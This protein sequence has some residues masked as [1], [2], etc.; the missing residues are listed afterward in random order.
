MT[1]CSR[2]SALLCCVIIVAAWTR[3]WPLRRRALITR[4]TDL[5][6]FCSQ[7]RRCPLGHGCCVATP[8]VCIFLRFSRHHW[9][10][11]GGA[12]RKW[13][14]DCS[15][16]GRSSRAHSNA[17]T[18]AP[19]SEKTLDGNCHASCL[20]RLLDSNRWAVAYVTL[21]GLSAHSATFDCVDHVILHSIYDF[22][23]DG[24]RPPVDR[25]VSRFCRIARS[26]AFNGQLSATQSVL[27]GVPE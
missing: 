25:V 2:S 16:R 6:C 11:S 3:S 24:R 15:S 9:H 20:V 10:V 21:L 5:R 13:C 12:Q 14:D 19:G 1:R 22:R 8:G 27:F 18:F 23:T 7:G 4:R 17:G 26:I